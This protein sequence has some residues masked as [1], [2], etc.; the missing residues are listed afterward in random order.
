MSGKEDLYWN[1]FLP[2]FFDRV[3]TIMRKNMTKIVEEYGLNSGHAIYLIALNLKNGQT[4]M[5]LSR[6]LDLDPANTNRVIKVLREGGFVYDDRKKQESKKYRVYLTEQG[7]ELS[8]KIMNDVVDLT[9]SYFEKV[10]H[11]NIL[12][13][14]NTLIAILKNMDPDIETYMKSKYANPYF[15]YLTT[16]PLDDDYPVVPRRL[17]TINNKK[18]KTE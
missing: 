14:R 1:S 8:T 15:T 2:M 11:E 3:G 7:W 10:P 12:I 5:E 17:Q 9:N 16:V 13:M 18:K 4:L 6:F